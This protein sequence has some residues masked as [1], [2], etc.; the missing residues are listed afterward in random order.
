MHD[1]NTHTHTFTHTFTHTH[2]H[3]F[4]SLSNVPLS[5]FPHSSKH[6]IHTYIYAYIH[7]Y[8]HITHTPSQACQ[9]CLSAPLY[10][11]IPNPVYPAEK[12]STLR[13]IRSVYIH[14]SKYVYIYTHTYIFIFILCMHTFPSLSNVPLSLFLQSCTKSCLSGRKVFDIRP[15]TCV[16]R[17]KRYMNRS[18][19]GMPL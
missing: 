17:P 7:T 10:I 1:I 16:P 4:P 6:F 2:T 14:T 13:H 9:M 19:K 18:H 8:I 12:F 3:T 5:R 11:P 15:K